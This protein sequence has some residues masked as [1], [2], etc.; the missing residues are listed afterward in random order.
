MSSMK[1]TSSKSSC[2]LFLRSESKILIRTG[3]FTRFPAILLW[4]I[5]IFLRYVHPSSK[6]SNGGLNGVY[7]MNFLSI[8]KLPSVTST[9][10]VYI[11]S[12]SSPETGTL[13]T[14]LPLLLPLPDPMSGSVV[15]V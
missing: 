6:G 3:K 5:V 2:A 15:T 11:L 1:S 4:S 14:P 9:V 8:I 10:H 12:Y 13:Y 7:N